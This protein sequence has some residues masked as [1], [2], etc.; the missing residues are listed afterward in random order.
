MVEIT[1][2]QSPIGLLLILA[3]KEGVVK[4]SSSNNSHKELNN[5]CQDHLGLEAIEGTN[6]TSEA[7]VRF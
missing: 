7:K 3:L 1:C 4:I 5:W 2:F 6:F